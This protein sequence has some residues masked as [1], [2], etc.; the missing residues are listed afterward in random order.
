MAQSLENLSRLLLSTL[1]DVARLS[2][3][4]DETMQQADHPVF[5]L[6]PEG[7][8]GYLNRAASAMIGV[9]PHRAVGTRLTT[10][11]ADGL[12]TQRRLEALSQPPQPQSWQEVW[13]REPQTLQCRLTGFAIPRSLAS[14]RPRVLLWAERVDVGRR[15]SPFPADRALPA[16]ALLPSDRPILARDLDRLRQKLNLGV[17]RFCELLG[18]TP[19]TFYL[20]RK[21]PDAPITSRTT[22]LHLRLLDAIPELAQLKAQPLDLQ[23]ALRTQR[24]IDL[25]FT[26]LA[27]L[28]GVERRSGYGWSRGFPASAQVQALTASLLYLVFNKPREVWDQYQ[29]VLDR[30]A[31]LEGVDIRA[32]PSWSASAQAEKSDE[33]GAPP[34][35]RAKRGRPFRTQG[36]QPAFS[37]LE[38][39]REG[40]GSEPVEPINNEDAD[41]PAI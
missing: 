19:V 24:G 16:G 40:A 26:D 32:T 37:S 36:H 14:D 4:L 27:L 30:Q 5:E 38:T 6:S 41:K 21:D 2:A 23:E 18:I 12:K 28:L 7:V 22:V 13:R 33:P 39:R 8:I 35:R 29:Y 10:Y 15:E 11:V 1:N 25:T 34:A 3:L 31:A 17:H 9:D 20:W